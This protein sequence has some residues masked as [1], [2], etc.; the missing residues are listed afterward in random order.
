VRTTFEAAAISE[1][2]RRTLRSSEVTY[3]TAAIFGDDI[4]KLCVAL[5]DSSPSLMIEMN[6]VENS[7][8]AIT[9]DLSDNPGGRIGGDEPGQDLVWITGNTHDIWNRYLRVMIELSS[10]GYPGCIGCAGPSAELPWNENLSRA[11]LA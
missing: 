10:A 2:A 1:L 5:T 8:D 4:E 3:R 11:R 7:S 6:H 9:V